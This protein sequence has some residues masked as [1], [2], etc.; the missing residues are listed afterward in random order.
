[1]TDIRGRRVLVTGAA[2]GIGRLLATTFAARGARLVIWDIDAEGLHALRGDLQ[3]R[4]SDVLACE[5]DLADRRQIGTVAAEVLRDGGPVD[6]LVNN[7]GV[8]TGRPLLDMAEDDV[9]RT[10]RVNTLALFWTVRA[11]LPAMLE[12][13]RGHIVT[14]ASAAGIA[15]TGRLTDYCSSK[16]AAFGFDEALRN[17]LKA[18]DSSIVTTIVCPYFTDTGMFEGASTR[19]PWLLPILEPGD[20]VRRTLAAVEKNRRRVVM[21]WFVYTTWPMRLLPVPV[22][23][24]L[25]KFFGASDSMERFTGRPDRS[26]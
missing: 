22:F 12:Q 13:D 16:F 19:F 21:P 8:V 10:F 18:M 24:A 14:I 17:E 3:A 1:M 11:F 25:L 2:S 5:C 9:E 23:D 15:G 7:A 26:G 4:G 6:I 20:V